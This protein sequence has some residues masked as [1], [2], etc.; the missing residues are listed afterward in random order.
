MH[1]KNYKLYWR[2]PKTR[3]FESIRALEVIACDGKMTTVFTTT[4]D[5]QKIDLTKIGE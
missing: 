2:N 1:C 4:L 3:Q 5:P